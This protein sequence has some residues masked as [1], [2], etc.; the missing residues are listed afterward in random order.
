MFARRLVRG[1]GPTPC[2]VLLVGEAGGADEH[3]QG[4]AF[5]G[6]AGMVLNTY[7]RAAGIPRQ[8]VHVDNVYP[9][10][11]GPGNP[12]PT[13]EQIGEGGPRLR[14]VIREVNPGV[15]GCLGATAS[16]WFRPGAEMKR[17]HGIPH[18]MEVEGRTRVV[19]A[20]LHPAAG[21]YDPSAA[22]LCAQDLRAVA[23]TA[24]GARSPWRRLSAA[25]AT[26]VAYP[27]PHSGEPVP[28]EGDA[29]DTEG[30][31]ARPLMVSWSGSGGRRSFVA[32]VPPVL[33]R[34]LLP[35]R[36]VFHHALHDLGTLRAMGVDTDR[37]EPDDTMV[38]AFDLMGGGQD[39]AGE[40]RAS[41]LGLSLKVLAYREL[42][43]VMQDY[44]DLV[45]PYYNKR[46]A[47]WID[48][49]LDRDLPEKSETELV[50]GIGKH[51]G[52]MVLYTPHPPKKRLGAIMVE[53][54]SKTKDGEH[55]EP[56][57][58]WR[59]LPESMRRLAEERMGEGF[60]SLATAIETVPENL[61]VDYSGTD[62]W[63]TKELEVRLRGR[64]KGRGLEGVYEIDRRAL[65]YYDLML[66]N[67]MPVDRERTLGL[68]DELE[69]KASGIRR[70]MRGLVGMR[71]F[72]PGSRDD[73]AG[74]LFIEHGLRAPRLT[75]GGQESTDEK[76]IKIL[77]QRVGQ[78]GGSRREVVRFL[79]LLLEYRECQKY[80]GTY[81]GYV[82]DGI[83]ETPSGW[84]LFPDDISTTRV[85]SGRLSGRLLTFPKRSELGL[86]VRGC[87]VAP[88]G[89]A[90]LSV[91]LSQIELRMMAEMS[92]DP[93]MLG[94]FARGEDLHE[95]TARKLFRVS[96]RKKVAK[97][98]RYIAKT[99]N[100]AILYGI[101]ARALL[102]QLAVAGIYDY[103]LRDCERFIQEWFDLF[104][105]VKSYLIHL[106][107][108][109]E[110]TGEVR[111]WVGRLRYVPNIALPR[112]PLKEKAE[113]DVGNFPIQAGSREL[114]K[115][116]EGEMVPWLRGT[117]GLVDPILDIHDEVLLEVD[118]DVV[119][120]VGEIV[121][122][123]M[124]AEGRK[125][126]G[127]PLEAGVTWGK[128]WAMEAEAA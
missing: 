116:A 30:S 31:R 111:D 57:K 55:G 54:L 38:M 101:T 98:L 113:R 16:R 118:E 37:V 15:I 41:P 112:G 66:R 70:E 39:N 128:S 34:T 23:E 121:R 80:L 5:A 62:A 106:C 123:Y 9:Y 6:K 108:E 20:C 52:R 110:R 86:R 68:R 71:G 82:L 81:L 25:P 32:K 88:R 43:L 93:A 17:D 115:I 76:S 104:P 63:A 49:L 14:A 36:L 24:S 45:R 28:Q 122:G 97:T 107:R 58:R 78:E 64:L 50:E 90:I 65:G 60:P 124:L 79:D 47:A 53:A 40:D 105:R 22:A 10:W 102:E 7:L 26:L 27:L 109:T 75:E 99:L 61:A 56:E 91:D 84:R 67:G 119:E 1:T 103:S 74:V 51:K 126:F 4:R 29:L 2:G 83:I 95:L 96:P 72:N 48:D 42:G 35:R 19:V 33:C 69:E 8:T 100:F 46:V 120:E 89:K 85:V 44:L 92:Q 87:F 21:F 13:R 117:R 77:R 12:V 73:V 94:A 127:V 114:V 125:R 18:E 59:K 3:I 11:T